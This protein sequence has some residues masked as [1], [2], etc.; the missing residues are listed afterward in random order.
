MCLE[1]ARIPCAATDDAGRF[2]FPGIPLESWDGE[3][4]DIVLEYGTR[5]LRLDSL[6]VAPGAVMSPSLEIVLPG[7]SDTSFPAD[8]FRIEPDR[9]SPSRSFAPRAAAATSPFSVFA[10]REGLVGKTTANGHKIVENDHFVALPSRRA[11]NRTDSLAD[12]E[13]EVALS[14][15]GRTARLPV[16]DVG[17]WNTKDDWWNISAFR[18]SFQDLA[19]GVP[20]SQAAFRDGYSGGLDGSGRVVKN[21]AGIDLG[22]GAFR[23]DL[24]MVDNGTISVKPLW[25]LDGAPGDRVAAKHWAKIRSS[26]NGPALDTVRCGQGGTVLSGPDSATVSSHWYLYYRIRWEDGSE[27]WTAEN[28]LSLEASPACED[29]LSAR[30]RPRPDFAT[31]SG[32]LLSIAFGT[33]DADVEVLRPDG[34]RIASARL[35][36]GASWSLPDHP[37]L[38]I[39]VVRAGTQRRVLGRIP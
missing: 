9:T 26:P 8:L 3:W 21:A 17:P 22:D 10:T 32:K 30:D 33:P 23:L 18:Q 11:L 31:I 1:P 38:Q 20:E 34:S 39:V 7:G 2:L 15:N 4:F 16:W 14:A 13:F 35:A 28:F 5:R 25:L 27:G 6:D 29:A 19:R 36:Q 37:G 24:A 12:L